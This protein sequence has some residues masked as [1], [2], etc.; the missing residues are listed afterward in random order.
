MR[1]YLIIM[2][3][4]GA[5]VIQTNLNILKRRQFCIPSTH[6]ETVLTGCRAVTPVNLRAATPS[7]ELGNAMRDFGC[8]DLLWLLPGPLGA[9]SVFHFDAQGSVAKSTHAGIR[10]LRFIRQRHSARVHLWPFGGCDIQP[11]VRRRGLTAEVYR[12]VE[13]RR[14]RAPCSWTLVLSASPAIVSGG[15]TG[16]ALPLFADLFPGQSYHAANMDFQGRPARGSCRQGSARSSARRRRDADSRR[17]ERRKFRRRHGP[18]GVV[19]GPPR[20][21][22]VPGY[23]VAGRIDAIGKGVDASFIGRDVF[24]LTRFGGYADVVCAPQAQVFPRPPEHVRSGGRRDPR[25]LPHR[26]AAHRRDGRTQGGRDGPHSFRRGR[27]RHRRDPDRQA[28]RGENH[29]NRVGRQTRRV[30]RAGRRSPD[31]LSHRGFRDSERVRLPA[32]EAS[33]LSSMRSAETR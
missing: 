5:I 22:V 11:A 18:P 15:Q 12:R 30:A 10:S 19:S 26:M 14:V 1:L 21:P 29:R 23:E 32:D 6:L 25:E 20:I 2:L 13:D 3:S 31:R 27:R 8:G 9:K 7:R 16:I 28:H 24:A 33:S 17:G 4:V